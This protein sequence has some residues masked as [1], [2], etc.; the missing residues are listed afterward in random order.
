MT[1]DE[2]TPTAQGRTRDHLANERTF[3][4]WVRTS[5]G[6]IGLG[7]V[8]ARMGLFLRQL[9]ML[10][11]IPTRG[12]QA[13]REFLIVGVVFLVM[14]TVITGWSGW[15]YHRVRQ[16]IEVDRYQPARGSVLALTIIVVVGGLVIVG[17]VL[18]RML[19]TGT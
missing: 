17:L 12:L 16:E 15:L 14:G 5:L 19:A 4:A 2:S 13:G 9:A 1:R 7:F 10:G 8:L 3:L 18:W 6:L 11:A